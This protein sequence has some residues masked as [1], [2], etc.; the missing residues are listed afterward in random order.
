MFTRLP[1]VKARHF[2][3]QRVHFEFV[4]LLDKGPI[5]SMVYTS[6][7]LVNSTRLGKMDNIVKIIENRFDIHL[8]GTGH[9]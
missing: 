6:L 9:I 3:R 7:A 1:R 2:P 8:H 4:I 5:R